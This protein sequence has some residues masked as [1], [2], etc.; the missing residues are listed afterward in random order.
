MNGPFI[1]RH[2]SPTRPFDATAMDKFLALS[3]R[4]DATSLS[5]QLD[6]SITL[7]ARP[8]L[9][10]SFHWSWGGTIDWSQ[11]DY[12][13]AVVGEQDNTYGFLGRSK[14]MDE[15]SIEN[16]SPSIGKRLRHVKAIED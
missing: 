15:A 1:A 10:A 2:L 11:V 12:R 16:S 8:V 13:Y 5:P 3:S 7:E 6:E 4:A 14:G 9:P